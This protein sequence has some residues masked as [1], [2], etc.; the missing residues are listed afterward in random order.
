MIRIID[1]NLVRKKNWTWCFHSMYR[2]F[3]HRGIFSK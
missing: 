3:C 2:D 1:Q